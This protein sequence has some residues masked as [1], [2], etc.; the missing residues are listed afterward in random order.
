M[1]NEEIIEH[2]QY[3]IDMLISSYIYRPPANNQ[4]LINVKIESFAIHFRCLYEFL[5]E[6]NNRS[7]DIKLRDF[8]ESES[9]KKWIALRGDELPRMKALY[10]RAHKEIAH[11]TTKRKAGTEDLEKPWPQEYVFNYLIALLLELKNLSKEEL[12]GAFASIKKAD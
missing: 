6:K 3:E 2:F 10:E 4:F 11:L 5:F 8:V 7:D 12:K 9:Y 1:T